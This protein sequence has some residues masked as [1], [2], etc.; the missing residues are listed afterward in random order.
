[1]WVKGDLHIHSKACPDAS[2]SVEEIAK[3]SEQMVDF[4]AIAGHAYYEDE[5]GKDQHKQVLRAR[6][7]YPNIPI[8]HSGEVEFPIERHCMF[9]CKPNDRE[10]ELRSE[11]VKR[12]DRHQGHIGIDEAMSCLKYVEDNWGDNAFMVF[13]HPDSPPVKYDDLLELAKSPVFK[14]MACYDRRHRVAPQTW[15]PGAEWD[16]LLCAGHRI[17]TRFGSDF[18][19]HFDDGGK[20]YYPGEFVQDQLQVRSNTYDEIFNAYKTGNFFCTTDNIISELRQ[21]IIES[22]L[23][24][25]FKCNLPVD[26][27][28]IISDGRIIKT[29]N[30]ISAEFKKDI[31]VISGSYYRLRGFGFEKK[32]QYTDKIYRP[33]FMSNPI[34]MKEK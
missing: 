22:K 2:I 33:V 32:C 16:K 7:K 4:L 5:W 24:I 11:L 26:Y 27:F 30:D 28:E 19:I 23:R 15:V 3:R 21:E 29:I 8:F 10:F 14:I 17:F 34:F 12:F 13:N 18:H 9:I 31:P 25:S 20:D 1:M 6:E